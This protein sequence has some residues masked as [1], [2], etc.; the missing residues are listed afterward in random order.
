MIIGI[1][2]D[3]TGI[4]RVQRMLERWPRFAPRCFTA[5][6][7][8]YCESHRHAGAHYA[9]RF[10]AKEATA[11]ALGG[12]FGWQEVE[13]VTGDPRPTL[14]LQGRAKVALGRRCVHLSLSHDGDHA[15]AIAIVET[16]RP[17]PC[18]C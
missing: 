2:V 17:E 16:P 10:A 12:R 13:V 15:V 9:V 14:T 11:K 8:A 6:E 4:A 18:A 5:R 7:R 3:I 1:G